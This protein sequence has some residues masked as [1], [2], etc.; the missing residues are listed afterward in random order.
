MSAHLPLTAF[1]FRPVVTP[2]VASHSCWHAIDLHPSGIMLTDIREQRTTGTSL[3]EG[4]GA[5]GASG[6]GGGAGAMAAAMGRADAEEPPVAGAGVMEEQI[7][8]AVRGGAGAGG[9]GAGEGGGAGEACKVSVTVP[10]LGNAAR[11]R[12]GF[13]TS[14]LKCLPNLHLRITKS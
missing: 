6:G 4:A 10:G 8:G 12:W 3:G 1:H 11:E 5:G 2:P 9:Q 14:D 13:M 7:V